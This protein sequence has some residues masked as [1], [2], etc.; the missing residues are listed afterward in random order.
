VPEEQVAQAREMLLAAGDLAAHIGQ[1]T[2][3][4]TSRA[5]LNII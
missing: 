3:A 4:G 2:A 1:V 5:R